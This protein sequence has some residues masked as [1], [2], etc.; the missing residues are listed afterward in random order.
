MKNSQIITGVIL[1]AV[2]AGAAYFLTKGT[3]PAPQAA[4]PTEAPAAAPEGVAPE[5]PECTQYSLVAGAWVCT[6]GH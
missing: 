2:I 1:I 5:A 4:V 6:S 3:E